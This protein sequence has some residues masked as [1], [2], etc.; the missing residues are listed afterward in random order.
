MF[1]LKTIV[2]VGLPLLLG[3]G[4]DPEGPPPGHPEYNKAVRGGG[5]LGFSTWAG[6]ARFSP[7]RGIHQHQF[8]KR[9]WIR[10]MMS[11]L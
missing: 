1:D 8:S 6:S 7:F 5:F 2:A 3:G 9:H 4:S 11:W 10:G